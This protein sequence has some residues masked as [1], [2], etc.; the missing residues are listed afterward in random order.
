MEDIHARANN[1]IESSN[2][3]EFMKN[4]LLL[5]G[6]KPNG[7]KQVFYDFLDHVK[8]NGGGTDLKM[9]EDICSRIDLSTVSSERFI[10]E[11]MEFIFHKFSEYGVQR[12]SA[13]ARV[14][15]RENLSFFFV[16][17]T[18]HAANDIIEH[19]KSIEVSISN[20]DTVNRT[21]PHYEPSISKEDVDMLTESMMCSM[22]AITM[23][24]CLMSDT[25]RTPEAADLLRRETRAWARLIGIP[26][27]SA[28]IDSNSPQT[29]AKHLRL[30]ALQFS[31]ITAFMALQDVINQHIE[32]FNDANV[33]TSSNRLPGHFIALNQM[34]ELVNSVLE[35][36]VN[37]PL[38]D[39]F[40]LHMKRAVNLEKTVQEILSNDIGRINGSPCKKDDD[41][42]NEASNTFFGP[43]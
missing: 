25:H 38:W 36:T 33:A 28:P 8:N 16:G 11:A 15:M 31:R 9:I 24:R 41:S 19:V 2:F 43:Y 3:N 37:T 12:A 29:P 39:D 32:T 26:L 40:K 27:F 1:S 35:S 21:S 17:D 13:I 7:D 22:P 30:R 18:A 6:K 23:I 4:R 10:Y 14:A 42:D 5:A 20:K 34:A